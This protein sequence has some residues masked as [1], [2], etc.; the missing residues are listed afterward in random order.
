MSDSLWFQLSL[1]FTVSQSLLK[2]KSMPFNNF[3]L[4]CPFSSCPQSFPASG[5]F[6]VSHSFT[7]GDQSIRVSAFAPILPMNIQGWFPLGLTGLISLQSKELSRVFSSTIIWKHQF[8]STQPSLWSKSHTHTWLLEKLCYAKS[9]QSCLTLC[10]PIDGSPPGSAVPGIL[11]ART[12]ALTI[13]TLSA[14]WCLCFLIHCLD[15]S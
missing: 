8:L 11:Q 6:P 7:S 5:S 14:K 1:F 15:L 3:I 4:C 13:Q 12:L 9:L 2:L 10:D